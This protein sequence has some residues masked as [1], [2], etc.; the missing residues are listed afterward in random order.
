MDFKEH[1]GRAWEMTLKH[2]VSL[3]VMTFVMIVVGCVTLGILAPVMAAGYVQSILLM[4]REGREP[5]IKDLFSEMRLFFPLLL[6]GIVAL[7]ATW[8]GFLLLF[9]P[10]ILVIAAL[11]FCCL[12][13]LPLMTDKKLGLM[14]AIKE[15]YAMA[16][17][18]GVSEHI[19][20]AFIFIVISAIG[21]AVL[22]GSLFTQPLA[23]VFL[24][25]VY[26][27]KLGRSGASA[28]RP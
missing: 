14:D 27:E 17:R 1:L 25:S 12:Y 7:I 13:M 2:I 8:I 18:D 22:L 21:N 11:V 16:V 6:F 24:L 4:L 15:S 19:V 3:I 26:E 10:G 5:T 28:P 20:V 9:I 23:T